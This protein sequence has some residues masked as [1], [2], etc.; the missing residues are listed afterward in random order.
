[1]AKRKPSRKKFRHGSLK[2]KS[3]NIVD[4]ERLTLEWD[5]SKLDTS[6]KWSLTI[7]ALKANWGKMKRLQEMQWG[8]I[9]QDSHKNP[10]HSV[11][12]NRIN[13][14]AVKRLRELDHNIEHLEGLLFSFRFNG[15]KRIWAIR[16][17]NVA[18]VLWWDPEHEICPMLR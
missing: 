18:H 6:G 10:H 17:K 3:R 2:K 7:E 11:D 16:M 1:M 15:K 4:A 8:A 12:I 9:L 14:K 13:S 5:F